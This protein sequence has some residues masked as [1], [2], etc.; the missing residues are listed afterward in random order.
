MRLTLP[1]KVLLVEPEPVK[2]IVKVV[3]PTP[4]TIPVEDPLPVT[5]EKST[6]TVVVPNIVVSSTDVDSEKHKV[7]YADKDLY[8]VRWGGC[9]YKGLCG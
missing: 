8:I 3:T 9:G 1:A 5:T 6:A 2:M 7:I 4:T